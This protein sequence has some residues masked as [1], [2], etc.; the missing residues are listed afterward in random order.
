MTDI[1]SFLSAELAEIGLAAAA[2]PQLAE[3]LIEALRGLPARTDVG[4]RAGTEAVNASES[5]AFELAL[6]VS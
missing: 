2:D 1:T 5:E 6:L 3:R 4:V